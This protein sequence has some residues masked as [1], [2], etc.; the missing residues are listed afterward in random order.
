MSLFGLTSVAHFNAFNVTTPGRDTL[1]V[2]MIFSNFL[3]GEGPIYGFLVGVV[4]LYGIYLLL[5]STVTLCLKSVE[6]P[7]E[8]H[9]EGV[10]FRYYRGKSRMKQKKRT[11]KY[12]IL[13]KR[14]RHT[15]TKFKKL[16]IDDH[17]RTS[18]VIPSGIPKRKKKNKKIKKFKK[19]QDRWAVLNTQ[20]EEQDRLDN[21]ER[22]KS[23]FLSSSYM[24]Y[25]LQYGINLDKFIEKMDPAKSFSIIAALSRPDALRRTRKKDWLRRIKKEALKYRAN[26]CSAVLEDEVSAQVNGEMTVYLNKHADSPPVVIDTGASMCLTPVLSDFI[27][28][29]TPVHNHLTGVNSE[30][31]ISGTGIVEWDIEDCQGLRMKLKV[32]AYYVPEANIRL[33][34]PQYYFREKQKGVLICDKD[35]VQLDLDEKGSIYKFPYQKMN[36]LPMML[37]HEYLESHR[38][39]GMTMEECQFLA[40]THAMPSIVDATNQNLTGSQKELLSWHHRLGHVNMKWIQTLAQQPRNNEDARPKPYLKARPGSKM[41]SCERP[42]CTACQLAKQARRTRAG[43]NQ[44]VGKH[45]MAIK[46][47]HVKPGELI[48]VDQYQS[49]F[50]GRLPNTK[51]K[52][53]KKH[54]YTGGTIMVD[55][56]SSLVYLDHQ[57]SLT[58]SETI[59]TKKK[60]E[61]FAK[62]CGVKVLSYRADNQPFASNE[63]KAEIEQ[64]NQT[65]SFSGVGAH[66]QNGV[67]ERAIGTITRLARAMLLHHAIMWPDQADLKLWPFAMDQA[68][69][70]WNNLPREKNGLSPM[71]IF[72]GVTRVEEHSSIIEKAHTWGC[73]VYV[74]DPKLQDGKKLPKWDPR[75]RRGMYLGVSRNHSSS[76]IANVLNLRT[77]HISPQFHLVF[78]D[79]FTT[80][81]NPEGHGLV[82]PTRF[83]A[84]TWERLI[85][86]GYE[87]SLDS[88]EDIIPQM[89]D[90]WLTPHER[91]I[92]LDRQAV[93][94]ARQQEIR[95]M[96]Q[97][98]QHD[99]TSADRNATSQ[100]TIRQVQVPATTE[101]R[102]ENPT[103]N[104]TVHD[105][106]GM[107]WHDVEVNE[108]RPQDEDDLSI[109]ED[110][111]VEPTEEPAVPEPRRR[112]KKKTRAA[113]RRSKRLAANAALSMWASYNAR[114]SSS[115]I[116][117]GRLDNAFIQGMNWTELVNGLKGGGT[118]STLLNTMEVDPDLET[119]E[120]WNPLAFAVKADSASAADNPTWEQ[121]MNGPDAEGY[122]KAAE[123]E[124]DTLEE[125]DTWDIVEREDWMNVLPSTW[126]FKCKRYPDGSIRKFKGRFCAR[127]D[128]QLEGVDFFE[129]FAPVVNWN[130]VRLLLV[131]SIVMG[132]ATSQADYT[133]AFVQSPIDKDPNWDSLTPEEKERSGVYVE[134]PRGFRQPGKVLK[135]KR[136][137]YGLRQSPRNF[138]NHLK[139]KLENIGFKAQTELDPCLFVSD[140]V[141]CLTYVDDTL[142]FSPKQEYIDEALEKLR[143]EGMDLEK[144]NDVAGFLGVHMDKT[145]GKITMTQKGLIARIIDAL[146][147]SGQAPVHTPATKPLPMDKEGDPPNGN[148]NYASVVGMLQYLQAHS[149]PDLTMAVSQCARYVH[150]PKR[151]HEQALERIGRYLLATQDKG[152]IYSPSE[153]FRV[154]CY[155]D[156][157][158]AGLY[159]HEDPLEPSVAKSRTGFVICIA[160]CPVI[161]SSKLQG[162]IALSTMEAEYNALS[163]AMRDLLP[164]R[165][166]V[167]SIASA[168][169]LD[170]DVL[171]EFQTTVHEDNNGCLTL[172]NMEPGRITPRSKHYA[173]KTH[174][175]RSH[176]NDRVRVQRIDTTLQKADILTKPLPR[177]K[178]EEIRLLL[179]GW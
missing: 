11:P 142:W 23:K 30:T 155:V 131:M 126:A 157:D 29:L 41:S 136:S 179:C 72:T 159:G 169:G 97:D 59:K 130:T 115:K 106:T 9:L 60:F 66:H 118:Y 165:N 147:V 91:R 87:M 129:T 82:N 46:A 121:A 88:E 99:A 13:G 100:G 38:V 53:K 105:T 62:E 162:S 128:R 35:G 61:R 117:H 154:D 135:L 71:E 137:L 172:A 8:I 63:F 116:R 107:G 37:T 28:P 6:N 84:D 160:N 177:Q 127:G 7:P 3:R 32:Q 4:F 14:G 50:P 89:D 122:M 171:T 78:D 148:F 134:M 112:N 149:R 167:N 34:S 170:E 103:Q 123:L 175:F 18:I 85:E 75:A 39:A 132:L 51:G 24:M 67:A 40:T 70:I 73:P 80:I 20:E 92:R 90:S 150:S 15:A 152:L 174:W 151:S 49:H 168:T 125:M 140:K 17:Q 139:G 83:D 108:P 161:W 76:T 158:F 109:V 164:F 27:T 124:V 98:Q 56:A 33:F 133:A 57:V 21:Y 25:D 166:I 5:L 93:R 173:V 19:K 74:L 95:D 36:N 43:A 114:K 45:D 58:T 81:Y 144:E 86:T 54:Q 65:I 111:R 176:L 120:T 153:E 178:F 52:E 146:G 10:P 26:I 110:P 141:I 31:P 47:D 2:W 22:K 68:V 119:V 77:G 138:F 143:E 64:N 1:G 42:L 96:L 55:S 163:S 113:T 12:Y 69:H 104:P 94:R 48:S 156:S 44:R 16:Q 102:R 145:D 101:V 79:K